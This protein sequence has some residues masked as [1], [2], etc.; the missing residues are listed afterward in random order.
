MTELV[1]PWMALALL[2]CGLAG[3]VR[4]LRG[5]TRAD[6][7]LAAQLL[8]TTA[9]AMLVVLSLVMEEPALVDVALVLAVLA[10]VA[11][12]CFVTVF[13]KGIADDP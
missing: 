3:L 5:P 10:A 6:R 2:V 9:T 12:I 1:L 13:S 11:V 7:M 4:V 8:G